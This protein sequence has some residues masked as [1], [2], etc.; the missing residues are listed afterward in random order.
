MDLNTL[1]ILNPYIRVFCSLS[2]AFEHHFGIYIDHKSRNLNSYIT[3]TTFAFVPASHDLLQLEYAPFVQEYE[4]R[5]ILERTKHHER[6]QGR[7]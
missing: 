7:Y 2:I 5:S 3:G 1:Q 4:A 6:P